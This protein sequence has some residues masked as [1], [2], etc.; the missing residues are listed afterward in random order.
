MAIPHYLKQF[1]ASVTEWWENN[2][3]ASSV[4]RLTLLYTTLLLAVV[5]ILL[6]ILYQLSVGQIGRNQISQ[7]EELAQQQAL[8]ANQLSLNDF[9][10][11][12][13]IQSE[14]SRQYILTFTENN[15]TY[16]QLSSIP[17]HI[18]TCPKTSRFPIW[19][20]KYN[21]LHLISGCVKK[22]PQGILFIAIDDESLYVLRNQ[23]ISASLIALLLALLLGIIT[24]F[25]FSRRVL[26][27]IHTFNLVAQRV[28]TG[29]MTARIPVSKKGDEYDNMA[30][31]INIMLSRLEDSFDAITAVTD[32]I[33]HDLR[34]P[35]GHLRQQIEESINKAEKEEQKSQNLQE[36]LEKLD[37]ILFTFTAMLELTRLENS[38]Q[39][40]HF[41][42]ISLDEIIDDAIDLIQPIIEN[43]QQTL[44]VYG[45]GCVV[46][47]E[48][49]LLFRTIYNLLENACKY[50]GQH[51]QISVN[52]NSAGV[53]ISDNG[54]GIAD[55]EKDKVFQ[56][57]YRIE[58]SRSIAGFGMGLALVKAILRIH[59]AQITLQDNN[60]GLQA[61]I[62]F[63]GT[64]N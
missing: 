40:T 59:Q 61:V 19:L 1:A 44:H 57:L 2:L 63:N 35:L 4:W 53:T 31:H 17:A 36:M 7:I 55:S 14:H 32:A 18:D 54:P 45:S 33:A 25:I 38:Q 41:T 30:K 37:D 12:F 16:G 8:L 64:D 62:Q 34:T 9:I 60:P 58:K 23:F 13:E 15:K 3:K 24:G 22:I 26:K 56:R 28:E 49:T 20:E 46:K 42:S 43:N 11:Q 10:N 48:P 47:G 27:R 50:A 6:V 51:A 5:A 39:S 29:E 52:I 21:E